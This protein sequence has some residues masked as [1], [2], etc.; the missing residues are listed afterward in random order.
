MQ[1]QKALVF[2]AILALTG[3][4]NF[5]FPGVYKIDIQQGNIVTQEQI[6]Q[7]RPGMTR[8]QVRFLLGTPLL[9]DSFNQERWDYYYSLK[10]GKGEREQKRL[11]LFFQGDQL[12]G[13]AG[14]WVPDSARPASA[15]AASAGNSSA[16]NTP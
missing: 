9:T 7:L 5:G 11:S 4:S 6:N 13:F 1:M 3:C 14:D 8:K 15:K 16:S 12:S 2:L 10:P